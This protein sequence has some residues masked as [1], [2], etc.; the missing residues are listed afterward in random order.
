MPT[1]FRAT[2]EKPEKFLAMAAVMKWS[3]IPSPLFLE[4]DFL[5]KRSYR[6]REDDVTI[7]K[8]NDALHSSNV[9]DSS[10][11]PRLQQSDLK[12]LG[13]ELN[14]CISFRRPTW[15][16]ISSQLIRSK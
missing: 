14:H 3:F 7:P 9:R 12:T 6:D 5:C 16:F 13:G 1:R 2:R 4:L 10:H 11:A 15:V 8:L